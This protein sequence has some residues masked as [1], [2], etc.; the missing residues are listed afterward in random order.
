[1]LLYPD[2][3]ALMRQRTADLNA[4]IASIAA[5]NGAT[6]MDAHALYEDIF[7]HGYDIGGGIVVTN[8]FLTGGV[9]SA[10]GFHP[11][12]IGYAIVATEILKHLNSVKGTDFELPDLAD[13]VFTADVP[14]LSTNAVAEPAAGPFGYSM[15]MWKDLVRTAAGI[16]PDVEVVFPAPSKRVTRIISR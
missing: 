14:V 10:D 9:F 11:S 12:N 13:A 5:A 2:E 15:Q 7:A 1:V 4:K 3:V 16:P 6:V 8:A